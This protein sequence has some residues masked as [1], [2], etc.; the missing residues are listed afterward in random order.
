MF[1]LQ[2]AEDILLPSYPEKMALFSCLVKPSSGTLLSVCRM[3]GK[4]VW[5]RKVS[6]VA[7]NIRRFVGQA[8]GPTVRRL[9]CQSSLSQPVNQ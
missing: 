7:Q 8:F 1:I 9:V 6:F 2:G 4:K 5:K 3:I